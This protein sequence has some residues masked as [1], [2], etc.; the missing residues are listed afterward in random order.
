[1]L[2]LEPCAD[3]QFSL[4]FGRNNKAQI[5]ISNRAY[6]W[7]EGAGKPRVEVDELRLIRGE[8]M[9]ESW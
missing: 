6:L 7:E 1:M 8:A 5:A 9:A 3:P 4:P 2:R